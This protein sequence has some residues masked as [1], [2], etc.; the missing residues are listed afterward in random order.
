[1]GLVETAFIKLK[2]NL[3]ITK[4]EQDLASKRQNQI[5]DHLASR[6]TFDRTFLTGSYARHTKTKKLKDVDI[7]CV[8]KSDGAD[9]DLR[10]KTPWDVLVHLQGAL[11]EKYTSPMPRSVAVRARSSSQVRMRCPRSMWYSP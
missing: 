3:E 11:A 6:I 9:S 7:F 8:L 10:D 4:S 5:R 1:M 2:S